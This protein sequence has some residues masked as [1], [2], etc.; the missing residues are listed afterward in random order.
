ME[1]ATIDGAGHFL[2]RDKPDEVSK[3]LVDWFAV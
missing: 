3:L 1:I 2:H